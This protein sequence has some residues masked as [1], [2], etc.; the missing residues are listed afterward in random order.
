MR[1]LTG[2][3]FAALLP[4]AAAAQDQ[5]SAC[6]DAQTQLEL[7]ECSARAYQSADGALNDAYKAAMAVVKD[8]SSD[9]QDKLRDAQRL[10]IAYRDKAC[11]IHVYPQSGSITPL[12]VN[13]CLLK[14]TRDRTTDLE[15]LAQG[16]GN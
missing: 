8:W 5:E 10:W 12:L 15:S 1:M 14:I 6:R 16:L 7:N 9:S 11:E 3:L 2:I 4:A 13:E